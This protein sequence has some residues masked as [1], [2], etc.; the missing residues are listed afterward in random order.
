LEN[1]PESQKRVSKPAGSVVLDYDQF[2]RV[3][4]VNG[5]LT[6]ATDPDTLL[7]SWN[8]SYSQLKQIDGPNGNT[9]C[10][11]DEASGFVA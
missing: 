8:M 5:I 6:G 9:A 10:C 7:W 3:E 2:N 4:S 1:R 11:L